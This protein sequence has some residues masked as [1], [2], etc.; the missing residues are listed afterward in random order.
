MAYR[1]ILLS[2]DIEINPGPETLD[3]C[4]WNLNSIVAYDFIRVSLIEA[5]NSAFNYDLIAIV[6]THIDS[7]IDEGRLSLAVAPARGGK[8]GQGGAV[9]PPMLKKM[10][11]VI[12]PNSMRK[13]GGGCVSISDVKKS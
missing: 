13:L 2:G 4:C 5:Y 12:L 6:E 10:V 7:T 9:A 1:T 11:L 3:F 8:G